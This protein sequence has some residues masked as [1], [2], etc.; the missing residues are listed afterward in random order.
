MNLDKLD[1][2]ILDAMCLDYRLN[3]IYIL[4][5]IPKTTMTTRLI[6][7]KDKFNVK[8]NTGLV[9]KYSKYDNL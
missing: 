7:L 9:Y 3:E 1:R 6:I 4:I 8:T 2:L 5:G